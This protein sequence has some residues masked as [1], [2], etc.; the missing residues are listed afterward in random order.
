MPKLLLRQ[1]AKVLYQITKDLSGK[2][3]DKAVLE[4]FKLLKANQML[5]KVDLIVEEFLQFAKEREGIDKITITSANKLPKQVTE[6]IAKK[7]S[8]HFELDTRIDES[9]VGGV[10]VRKGNTIFNTSVR[11]D[12]E[13]LEE[14]FKH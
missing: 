8:K 5:K 6:E 7:F 4:F 1:Y 10:K 14:A 13:S 11:S 9:L 3:L 12:L 2:E